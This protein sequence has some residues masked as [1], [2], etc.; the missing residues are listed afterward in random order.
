LRFEADTDTALR[1]I[2][3][4]FREQMLKVDSSIKLPF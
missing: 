3:N 4:E 1:R 2:Q